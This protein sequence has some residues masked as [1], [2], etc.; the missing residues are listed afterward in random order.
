[1]GLHV[2]CVAHENVQFH[3]LIFQKWRSS[4][5]CENC[6]KFIFTCLDLTTVQPPMFNSIPCLDESEKSFNSVQFPLFLTSGRLTNAIARNDNFKCFIKENKEDNRKDISVVISKA[7]NLIVSYIFAERAQQ[8]QMISAI[9][10]ISFSLSS[11]LS[12]FSSSTL[13][14]CAISFPASF[15]FGLFSLWA[16]E[17]FSLYSR[18]TW[19]V[20]VDEEEQLKCFKTHHK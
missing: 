7:E 2:S 18:S 13:R 20:E 17:C 15:D 9:H 1:M 16:F 8:E 12:H 19:T 14:F 6:V 10:F 11:F 5:N 3:G 4:C